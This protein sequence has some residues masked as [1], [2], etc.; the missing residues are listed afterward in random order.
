MNGLL[1]PLAAAMLLASGQLVGAADRGLVL[2]REHR[3][4]AVIVLPAQPHA[5]IESGYERLGRRG[6]PL[7]RC[8]DAWA[9][10]LAVRITNE[11]VNEIG[12]G[13]IVAPVM[14][15]SPTRQTD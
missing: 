4:V 8:P 1:L 2:V 6:E 3:A 5:G 15:W 9:N 11:R 10:T 7:A 13:G 14:F 12:T